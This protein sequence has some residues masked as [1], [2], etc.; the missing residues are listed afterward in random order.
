MS[1]IWNKLID[2]KDDIIDIFNEKATEIH[3]DG[4]IILIAENGWINRVWA[5]DNVRRV[6]IDVVD[7]LTPKACG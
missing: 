3:E 1:T 5:N 7:V 6:S 2:C 4:L